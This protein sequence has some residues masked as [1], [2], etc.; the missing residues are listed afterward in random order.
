LF[1]SIKCLDNISIKGRFHVQITNED[2]VHKQLKL[3]A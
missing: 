1:M 3:V 2:I